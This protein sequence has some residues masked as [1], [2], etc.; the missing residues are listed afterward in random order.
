MSSD[1]DPETLPSIINRSISLTPS[2]LAIPQ[3]TEISMQELQI[4]FNV[5]K[6]MVPEYHGGHRD[7]IY[8]L[9]NSE[10]FIGEFANTVFVQYAFQFV[11]SQLRGEVRDL[12]HLSSPQTW[13]DLKSLL[14]SKYKDPRNEET[15]LTAL[16][17]A[18]Q[19]PNQKYEDFYQEIKIK[20]QS[21]KEFAHLEY[22][23]NADHIAFKLR[24]YDRQSLSSFISG[25]NEPYRSY[26]RQQNP[27][28][29]DSC[30]QFC[31]DY[32]NLQM[33]V[34]YKNFLRT[35]LYKRQPTQPQGKPQI[36]NSSQNFQK[37][38]FNFSSVQNNTP[39][40]NFSRPTFPTGPIQLPRP[41]QDYKPHY[42][43]NIQ[44]FRQPQ[45]VFSKKP[46][47]NQRRINPTPMSVSTAHTSRPQQQQHF[48]RAQIPPKN[49]FP[50]GPK[51]N[52]YSIQEITHLENDN[53]QNYQDFQQ[54]QYDAQ[55]SE[56]FD[57]D[58]NYIPD[59]EQ[60][61]SETNGD[62]NFCSVTQSQD[63]T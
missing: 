17:T 9:S 45:N 28:N 36:S 2:R 56:E 30:V 54:P 26:V 22:H 37:S 3:R 52:H 39:Q 61:V 23:D 33:Q 50:I 59:D 46:I 18:V 19:K 24:D 43:I 1:S 5:A 49:S 63:L 35:N 32:D 38:N 15:L 51:P 8:F 47:P 44:A 41:R 10:K 58:C 11:I 13:P 29:I 14:L 20:I 7:L 21:L 60:A 48:N 4:K 53:E 40:Q 34:D 62:E 6:Y 12:V 31:R 16:Y 42:P 55:Y 57:Y 25:L 27:T